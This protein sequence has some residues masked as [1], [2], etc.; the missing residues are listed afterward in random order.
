MG[1]GVWPAALRPGAAAGAGWP[2]VSQAT[3]PAVAQ[4]HPVRLRH[5]RAAVCL[6]SFASAR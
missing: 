1:S 3:N 2:V 6:E 5:P 4:A